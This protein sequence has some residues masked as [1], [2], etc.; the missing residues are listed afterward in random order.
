[1]EFVCFVDGLTAF[2]P[3]YQMLTEGFHLSVFGK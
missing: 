2:N 1:M 3:L